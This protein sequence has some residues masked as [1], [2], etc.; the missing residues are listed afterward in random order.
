MQQGQHAE[1]QLEL[2]KNSSDSSSRAVAVVSAYGV[3]VQHA[4]CVNTY[5]LF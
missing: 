4:V 2:N 1:Q 5:A 3:S